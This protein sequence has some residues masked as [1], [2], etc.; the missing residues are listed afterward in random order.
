M[1]LIHTMNNYNI[2]K[3]RNTEILFQFQTVFG[4]FRKFCHGFVQ[5][6]GT[7]LITF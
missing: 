3:I 1:P 5:L 4:I 7:V 6:E 2:R